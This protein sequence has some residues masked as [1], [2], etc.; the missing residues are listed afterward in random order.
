ML[1][2]VRFV[3]AKAQGKA[4]NHMSECVSHSLNDLGIYPY[5]MLRQISNSSQQK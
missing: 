2:S 3:E 5:E 4:V 1:A